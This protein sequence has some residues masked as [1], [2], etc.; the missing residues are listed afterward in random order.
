MLINIDRVQYDKLILILLLS[1]VTSIA[2][3]QNTLPVA[4]FQLSATNGCAP[5]SVSIINSSLNAAQYEWNFGNGGSSIAAQPSIVYSSKGV[6]DVS[7]I[8]KDTL[9]NSDTLLIINAITVNEIPIADFD[10]TINRACLNQN[11]INFTNQSTA[12]LNYTWDFGDGN[13]SNLT[14]PVYS[15]SD[16][17]SYTVTL[18]IADSI[19]CSNFKQATQAI[20]I[21]MTPELSFSVNDTVGCDTSQIFLFNC[22]V[23]S[24]TSWHWSFGDGDTSLIKN[25]THRYK[26]TGRYDVHLITTNQFGCSDTLKKNNY[27]QVLIT[28]NIDFTSSV[29]TGC[30]PLSVQLIADRTNFVASYQWRFSDGRSRNGDTVQIA[31]N[32]SG[33]YSITLIS[34]NIN[35]CVD[36][37]SKTNYIT[38]SGGA[39]ASFSTDSSTLCKNGSIGF[40]NTSQHAN[41]CLFLWDFG[42]SATSSAE[43]PNHS[44][45]QTGRYTVSLIVTDSTGCTNTDSA[46]LNIEDLRAD[47]TV[48]KVRGCLPLT[49]YFQNISTPADKWFWD[50]GD[51]DTSH[52]ENPMHLYQS[53]GEFDVS[54]VIETLSGCIDSI[55]YQDLILAH[56]DSLTGSLTDTIT[57]CLPLPIDFSSNQFGSG[58][59]VW[60]F[61]NGD[62]SMSRNPTYTYRQPG[63]FT[64]T[65]KTTSTDG[66]PVF[67]ENYTTVMI[68]SIVPKISALQFNCEQATLQ[69]TDSTDNISSWFWNFGDGTYSTL[70]SPIHQF[71]DTLV[72]DISVTLINTNGCMQSVFFPGFIDFTNCFVGGKVPTLEPDS[73]G[74]ANRGDSIKS[75]TVF[76]QR[77][78]PEIVQLTNPNINAFA[79][80][81]DFG[82]GDT[83]NLEDPLHIYRMPGV[84]NVQ[85]I[86]EDSLGRDTILWMNYVSINGPIA[87]FSTTILDDCDSATATFNNVSKRANSWVWQFAK[88]S[89]ST[90]NSPQY[91]FPYSIR[92]HVVYL[93]VNDSSGCSSSKISILNFPI[94][95]I[96]FILP[97]SA[98]VGD[99][100]YFRAS[101]SLSTYT[102]SFGDGSADSSFT[103]MHIYSNAGVYAIQVISTD[104]RGCENIH[105]LDS[106][107]IIGSSANFQIIDTVQCKNQ[108]F[109]FVPQETSA[110][111]YFWNFGSNLTSAKQL[112]SIKLSQ[113]GNYNIRL[114]VQK[115]GCQN[116]FTNPILVQV[117][118]VDANFTITQLN[119]CYPI[120]LGVTDTNS[121]SAQWTWGIDNTKINSLNQYLFATLD[122]SVTVSLKVTAQN[123]CVDSITKVFIPTALNSNFK[124]SDTLGCAP[125][126]VSFTNKAVHSVHSYWSFGDGDTSSIASPNHTYTSEGVYTVQLI[127]MSLDGCRDTTTYQNSIRVSSI[128]A[129][130]SNAFSSSCA[131]MLVNFVDLSNHAISWKWRFGD[132]M[133]STARNPLKI[134]NNSGGFD[135][136]L[137][138]TNNEGCKD[139]LTLKN[140]I[141]V[142]GP[143]TNFSVSDSVVCGINPVQFTDSSTDAAQWNWFFGD[144]NTSNQ[145]NPVHTYTNP[146]AYSITLTT[147]DSFGCSGFFTWAK[148]LEMNYAPTANF[149]IK[150]SVG[151][152]PLEL[153]LACQ[154]TNANQWE[155]NLGNGSVYKDSSLR[156]TAFNAGTY[157]IL[158]T[159]KNEAGCSDSTRFDSLTVLRT[160]NSY[161][162]PIDPICSNENPVKLT[163]QELGG[164]WSGLSITDNNTGFYN[165]KLANNVVDTVMYSFQGACPASDTLLIKIKEAPEVDFVANETEACD[166]LAV[167][168]ETVFLKELSADLKPVYKWQQNG[169]QFGNTP[170]VNKVFQS[171][172]YSISLEVLTINGCRDEIKKPQFIMVFDSI[173]SKTNI[174]RVSV[175]NDQEVLVEWE[176][177]TDL[178]FTH[179]VL[180]RKTAL[181]SVFS[182]IAAFSH[183]DQISYLDDSLNTTDSTYCYK[184]V[185]VNKCGLVMTLSDVSFHCTINVTANKVGQSAIGVRWSSYVG[186]S[187]EFY[188]I[189][190]LDKVLNQSNVIARVNSTNFEF[191][192]TSAYCNYDYS[193]KVKATGKAGLIKGSFSDTAETRMEGIAQF[194]KSEIIRVAVDDNSSVLVEW[195][196]VKIAPEFATGYVI[197]RSLD[198]KLFSPLTFIPIGDTSYNDRATSVID[199]RYFYQIEVLNTCVNKNQLTNT[200]SSI[201]L[202]STQIDNYTGK[203]RWTGYEK[204]DGGVK[205]YEIQRLNEFNQWETIQIVPPEQ[206]EIIINF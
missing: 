2:Q 148:M 201:L 161:I 54:L 90:T 196:P 179:Y 45:N 83:S 19:G 194:Q 84:Y 165:P 100:L 69:L 162:Q 191:T 117:K 157:S 174:E 53:S 145:Q 178:D 123:G 167:K 147:T 104:S 206:R 6:Y 142:P 40:I 130:Y 146:G 126:S 4:D 131:P 36:S 44:F 63:I 134:Y 97:D 105:L 58:S 13:S 7:L 180:Y 5:L 112:P 10:Q 135:V 32:R 202:N 175:L 56:D 127:T 65:L 26:N 155:W 121:N 49:A 20:R 30:A 85:L 42:D 182:E 198:N 64:V 173:L 17:G 183:A 96:S 168:F 111:S 52:Q 62:T 188:E 75:S 77:C 48:S 79:W 192:D 39:I 166:Q 11:Q 125:L 177:N 118:E 91:K 25:P 153:E 169:I 67:V 41:S 98:C 71:P 73:G 156:Y 22:S 103:P 110:N 12:G 132:G 116:T 9:G 15:Y 59:W 28:P 70:H 122:S 144:G 195:S 3:G 163:S 187:V 141:F 114:T 89:D 8:V 33:E 170:M 185:S 203:L 150:D 115:E 152:A 24:I 87:N 101:D 205:S 143:I 189:F 43:H 61:G 72:Y 164:V 51:G 176:K 181:D 14:N 78:A 193:Y 31:F 18:M 106:I 38:V 200:G 1:S 109:A 35:G 37:T 82:D 171:G 66:C 95:R 68:Q 23:D 197:H 27:I 149:Q 133:T 80:H 172:L 60:D 190:R 92:N 137:S 160:P 102:W 154:S 107:R 76:A 29:T 93:R 124:I 186:G 99:S 204:W 34:T 88:Y 139:T 140:D 138:V 21:V 129:N 94:K 199:E 158:L 151:C 86:T 128:Q 16:S 120:Q 46:L 74:S 108:L 55:H 81:W 57:G 50:F 159:V 47:F 136:S 119:H 113:A 184:I